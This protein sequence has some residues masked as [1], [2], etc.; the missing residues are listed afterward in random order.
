MT[1]HDTDKKIIYNTTA[2]LLDYAATKNI[3][4]MF[5][6]GSKKSSVAIP[7]CQL[8]LINTNLDNIFE[9]P[10]IIAHEISHVLFNH[11]RHCDC[12]KAFEQEADFGALALL[13]L[14]AISREPLSSNAV[15]ETC[16]FPERITDLVQLFQS[17]IKFYNS[18]DDSACS[19]S[20]T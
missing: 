2:W 19:L 13:Q 8:I 7:K 12:N 5:I 6:P 14:Y 15:F 1:L 16:Y 20:C 17:D 9:L 4:C 3:T 18:L 11:E 10:F